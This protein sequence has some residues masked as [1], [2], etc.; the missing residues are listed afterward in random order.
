VTSSEP[1]I[2]TH[3]PLL[4]RERGRRVPR[5]IASHDERR[6]A[7]HRFWPRDPQRLWLANIAI[8]WPW[9]AG[10]F[11]DPRAAWAL[12]Y[13]YV[14]NVIRFPERRS[15]IAKLRAEIGEIRA[16]IFAQRRG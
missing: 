11:G 5:H 7:A 8:G 3:P 10:L 14:S 15:E 6:V 4:L 13:F 16:N 2:R 9:W 1:P 12:S